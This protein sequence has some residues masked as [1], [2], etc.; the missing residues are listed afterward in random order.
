MSSS[1]TIVRFDKDLFDSGITWGDPDSQSHCV[2]TI[3]EKL[4]GYQRRT[5][6]D[7]YRDRS[8]DHPSNVN[9]LSKV[10]QKRLKDLKQDDIDQLWRFRFTGEQR[11]WGIKR[12]HIFHV[13]WW[14]PQHKVYPSK[15]KHT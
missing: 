4:K 12:G 3:C 5:W 11:I 15:K 7:I 1:L 13:L 6:G 2:R 8:R 14:D 10:A 9:N